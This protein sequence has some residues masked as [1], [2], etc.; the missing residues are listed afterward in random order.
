M[1]ALTTFVRAYEQATIRDESYQIAALEW[2]A[3]A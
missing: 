1:T 2:V 3:S